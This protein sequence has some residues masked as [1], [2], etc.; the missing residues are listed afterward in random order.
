[1]GVIL[2][3]LAIFY[4]ILMIGLEYPPCTYTFWASIGLTVFGVLWLLL[5]FFSPKIIA[6]IVERRRRKRE[7]DTFGSGLFECESFE[8]EPFQKVNNPPASRLPQVR[9]SEGNVDIVGIAR[10]LASEAPILVAERR[11]RISVD[12]IVDDLEDQIVEL[13]DDIDRLDSVLYDM[14]CDGED[15]DLISEYRRLIEVKRDKIRKKRIQI[16]EYLR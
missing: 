6:S 5:V 10:Y 12:D 8:S 13:N 4:I 3:Y 14:E 9:D 2:I 16:Y 1:M 15:Q 11:R 7:R